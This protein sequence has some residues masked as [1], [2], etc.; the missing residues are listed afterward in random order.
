[1][2]SLLIACHTALEH[3]DRY[4]SM[5]LSAKWVIEGQLRNL[6]ELFPYADLVF[7]ND[8]EA[9][10]FAHA[11]HWKEE[12]DINEIA[13]NMALLPKLNPNK[14]RICVITQGSDPV[15][16]AVAHFNY[17]DNNKEVESSSI[18]VMGGTCFCGDCCCSCD[19]SKHAEYRSTRVKL[20]SYPVK[21]IPK[22]E[23]KD[24]NGCGD[25][26]VGA[27][28][29]SFAKGKE[30]DKCV[31]N[32]NKMAQIIARQDGIVFPEKNEYEL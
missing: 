25:S 19:P 3:N 31:E 29:A 32:G 9:R 20:S 23:L 1:M 11:M 16:M 17:D 21:Q 24:T 12:K 8:D 13:T 26:F 22:E 28:L 18:P 4:F 2:E 30:L 27:F 14:P 7:C 6:L 5:N 15:I 10:C